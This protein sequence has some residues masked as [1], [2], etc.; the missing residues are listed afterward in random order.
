[1]FELYVTGASP[2]STRAITNLRA[3]CN[4]YLEGRYS[5]KIIDVYQHPE[6]AQSVQI[7]ALPMLLCKQP[8]P[9][10]KFIGDLSQTKKVLKGLGL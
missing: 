5:L 8:L 4:Q 2:N 9:E 10:R 1:M 3:I 7:W 6:V